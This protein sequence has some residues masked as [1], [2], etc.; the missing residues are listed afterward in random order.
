MNSSTLTFFNHQETKQNLQE[1]LSF[2]FVEME[3]DSALEEEMNFLT[4]DDEDII[5]NYYYSSSEELTHF[6]PPEVVVKRENSLSIFE[7]SCVENPGNCENT[8]KREVEAHEIIEM[9]PPEVPLIKEEAPP[10]PMD[11]TSEPEEYSNLEETLPIEATR[12]PMDVAS[13]PK[14]YS[15]LEGTALFPSDDTIS[16]EISTRREKTPEGNTSLEKVALSKEV[17]VASS[18]EMTSAKTPPPQEMTPP[19]KESTL[20]PKSPTPPS[21][22]TTPAPRETPPPSREST[23]PL[24][25]VEVRTK[26]A[27]STKEASPPPKEDTPFLEERTPTETEVVTIKTEVSSKISSRRQTA[28]EEDLDGFDDVIFNGSYVEVQVCDDDDEEENEKDLESEEHEINDRTVINSDHN[29]VTKSEVKSSPSTSTTTPADLNIRSFLI[30]YLEKRSNSAPSDNTMKKF[31]DE[32]V[33]RLK[34][35]QRMED[36]AKENEGKVIE[37]MDS[38][39]LD[40]LNVSAEGPTKENEIS[41]DKPEVIEIPESQVVEEV[42]K[43][44]ETIEIFES[45]VIESTTNMIEIPLPDPSATIE[46]A[47]SQ[48]PNSSEPIEIPDSQALNSSE[49]IEIPDSQQVIEIP[50]TQVLEFEKA[51]PEN[52]Q[53]AGLSNVIEIPDSQVIDS[54]KVDENK[55]SVEEMDVDKEEKAI[56]D[57]L[58]ESIEALI[59]GQKNNL[60]IQEELKKTTNIDI[61]I[62]DLLN[63]VNDVDDKKSE[64]DGSEETTET[65]DGS[66]D[67]TED[68]TTSED[69][70]EDPP[71]Q[72][73]QLELDLFD[74]M[75]EQ[76][77]EDFPSGQVEVATVKTVQEKE[78]SKEESTCLPE[79]PSESDSTDPSVPQKCFESM[80]TQTDLEFV[81]KNESIKQLYEFVSKLMEECRIVSEEN[82]TSFHEEKLN[83]MMK[84]V[85]LFKP[86]PETAEISIQTEKIVSEK[87]LKKKNEK[88]RMKLLASSESSESESDNFS[89]DSESKKSF[90]NSELDLSQF[91]QSDLLVND[92]GNVNLGVSEEG[93]NQLPEIKKEKIPKDDKESLNEEDLEK[94]REEEEDREIER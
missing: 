28:E 83:E 11:V 46:I 37:V 71:D 66:D 84:F 51:N 56:E 79:V 34:T 32:I 5:N 6:S 27:M 55:S 70:P 92:E 30:D 1:T 36:V 24:E 4:Q 87:R 94:L 80:E 38:Q 22:E 93:S 81:H 18:T 78:I 90:D 26:E 43:S 16:E 65:T 73:K 63:P 69:L 40:F 89:S 82:C 54:S 91:L 41:A 59:K 42:A 67:T 44:P 3:M 53:E 45:Q 2:R 13:E 86:L 23:P 19:L 57:A 64:E 50:D 9:F 77:P 12:S 68:T 35:Y 14:E 10:S 48:V 72:S 33:G 39:D 29:Y 75:D 52:L 60:S 58:N 20:P 76:L 88:E 49:D 47:E 21:K 17:T 15:N 85:Q 7:S 61:S 74:D 25:K 31:V 8:V 62:D